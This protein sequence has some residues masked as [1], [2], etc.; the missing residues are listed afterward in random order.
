MDGVG[1][2]ELDGFHHANVADLYRGKIPVQL[3]AV[4]SGT[5]PPPGLRLQ[6]ET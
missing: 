2:A 3:L 4:V 6:T 5:T 1:D